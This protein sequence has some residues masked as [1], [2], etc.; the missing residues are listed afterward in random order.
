MTS[1]FEKPGAS[2]ACL[3][4]PLRASKVLGITQTAQ[5]IVWNPQEKHGRQPSSGTLI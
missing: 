4:V 1:E 2:R 5:L 3:Q